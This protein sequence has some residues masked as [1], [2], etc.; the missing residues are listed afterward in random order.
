MQPFHRL[1]KNS[2]GSK[3][4]EH[5]GGLLTSKNSIC[6]TINFDFYDYQLIEAGVLRISRGYI[7]RRV[8]GLK[9]S[10]DLAGH[11]MRRFHFLAAKPL[12][13]IMQKALILIAACACKNC[14]RA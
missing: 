1:P 13:A 3:Y 7:Q 12:F 10:D 5:M 11:D 6:N 14:A 2:I 8:Q 9:I 4:P